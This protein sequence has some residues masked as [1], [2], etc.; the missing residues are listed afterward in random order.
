[1]STHQD[2]IAN[3]QQQVRYATQTV[4]HNARNTKYAHSKSKFT[5]PAEPKSESERTYQQL[6][7]QLTESQRGGDT[8]RVEQLFQTLRASPHVN[9]SL[10]NCMVRVAALSCL[11]LTTPR[12]SSTT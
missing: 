4:L 12:S 7:H 1:M 8:S 11:A 3:T 6:Y 2:L 9:Y 10:Y 5:R